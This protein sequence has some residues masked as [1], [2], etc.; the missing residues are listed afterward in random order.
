MKVLLFVLSL[1][2]AFLVSDH[3]NESNLANALE[4][5]WDIESVNGKALVH[6]GI[7]LMEQPYAFYTEFD[8]E[9]K[10]FVGSQGAAISIIG[11]KMTYTAE[12]D[13][14]NPDRIGTVYEVTADLKANKVTLDFKAD[15]E[16]LQ[17]VLT[18]IDRGEGDLAG[19]WRITDRMRN[20]E[21]SAMKLGARKTI[22]MITGS[23]FQW[24]AFNPESRQFSGT[25]GGTVFLENG[26]YNE[27]I[28][29]FSKNPDRVGADLSFDYKVDGNKWDHSG[30]SSTG[31]PIREIW[32]KQ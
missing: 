4:G 24:V 21:M 3:S 13:T 25:G 19:A 18:R 16:S 14:W 12:F 31:N 27:H 11:N 15:N 22:K 32:T 23:R 5:A 28:E 17:M 6:R 8:V 9:N 10:K 20:G 2:A 7:L 30:S 1:S 29:F 26:K